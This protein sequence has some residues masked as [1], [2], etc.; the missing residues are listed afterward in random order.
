MPATLKIEMA[1][2]TA[3]ETNLLGEKIGEASFHAGKLSFH[4]KPWKVQAF[5]IR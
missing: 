4:S 2:M 3:T 1:A 5:E